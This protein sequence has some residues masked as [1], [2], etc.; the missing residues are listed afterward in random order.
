MTLSGKR[1]PCHFHGN[2]LYFAPD[3]QEK[4]EEIG[5]VQGSHWDK[6]E[7]GERVT[8]SERTKTFKVTLSG[9]ETIYF[10]RYLLFGKPFEYYLRPSK[11]SVEVFSY[12]EMSK[13]GIPVAEPLALGEIRRF[14][15]LFAACIVTRGIPETITLKEYAIQEW[16]FLSPQQRQEAFLTISAT[17]CQHLRTMHAAGF[18]HFDPKWRN[19]LIHKN[20]SGKI[21]GIWWIDSPR[22]KKLPAWRREH[23]IVH[24]LASLSRLALS[25]LSRS[26][27]LRFLYAYC[28]S[29][30]TQA[31]VKKLTA[32]INLHLQRNPPK[33]IKPTRRNLQ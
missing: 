31:E 9:G 8:R 19:I 21:E 18:F 28:G 2:R 7:P 6:L 26:Q 32:K 16:T 14:G 1:R 22:G 5:L 20:S 23:G 11:T 33:L 4:L 12:K 13:L 24:D 17:V 10:K 29:D 27:R 30:T 15:S 25:F 3:W